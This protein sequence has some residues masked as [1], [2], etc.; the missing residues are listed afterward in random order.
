M[1][2]EVLIDLDGQEGT[3]GVRINGTAWRTCTSKDS[4]LSR[5]LEEMEAMERHTHPPKEHV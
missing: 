3:W 4:A 2:T 1:I 5:V